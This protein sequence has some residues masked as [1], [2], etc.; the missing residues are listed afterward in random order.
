[1]STDKHLCLA[2]V[3][4]YKSCSKQNKTNK[5]NLEGNKFAIATSFPSPTPTPPTPN[6]SI[7]P[8]LHIFTWG[9]LSLLKKAYKMAC[10]KAI[11]HVPH[12]HVLYYVNIS[13]FTSGHL[14]SL[15]PFT[16]DFGRW[17]Y[18]KEPSLTPA[19]SEALS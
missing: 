1:M 18:K 9:K 12:W 4:G 7:L 15:F 19:Q 14:L 13:I 17:S 6:V 10:D 11:S 5:K 8:S 3:F 2:P 16:A